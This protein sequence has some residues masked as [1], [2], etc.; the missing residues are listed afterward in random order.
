MFIRNS[1]VDPAEGFSIQQDGKVSMKRNP[2][3][4]KLRGPITSRGPPTKG[5]PA[6]ISDQQRE[7]HQNGVHNVRICKGIFVFVFLSC[8]DYWVGPPRQN[9]LRRKPKICA[10][11]RSVTTHFG[12][13][14]DLSTLLSRKRRVNSQGSFYTIS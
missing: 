2:K 10:V 3:I 4:P 14:I 6:V 1:A 5:T 7:W 12:F 8:H 11:I 13:G 9:L